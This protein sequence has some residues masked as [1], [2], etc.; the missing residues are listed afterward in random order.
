VLTGVPGPGGRM[1]LLVAAAVLVAVNAL[2]VARQPERHHVVMLLG[3]VSWVAANALW[4]ADRPVATTVPFLAAF[5]ILTIVGERLELSR[6][7]RPGPVAKT[8]FA[9]A[10]VVFAV[11]LAI[12]PFSSVWGYRVAGAGLLVQALWLWRYDIARRTVRMAGLT[13]YMAVAFIAGY[14]WLAVAGAVW[15]SSDALRGF[16]AQ[17]V[18]LHAIFLGFVFSMIFAHAPVILPAVTGVRLPYRAWLYAPLA[19]LHVALVVRFAGAVTEDLGVWRAGGIGTEVAVVVF[20]V[21]AVAANLA[22]RVA[23]RATTVPRGS[24]APSPQRR[25]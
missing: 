9:A 10:V 8:V 25:T 20:I 16:A 18:G 5:L 13:R 12:G 17:D 19:L 15:L 2:L 3:A 23:G 11:G 22:S 24:P 21:S 14:V 4:L 1:L 7:V 6:I